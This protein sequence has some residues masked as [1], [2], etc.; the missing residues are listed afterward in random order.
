MLEWNIV[1]YLDCL[2]TE[3][4]LSTLP[5]SSIDLC[6]TD[7]PWNVNLKKGVGR[8]IEKNKFIYDDNKSEETYKIWCKD[9]FTELKRICNTVIIYCGKKKIEINF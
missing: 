5:D 6:I 1:I 9:W 7:P 4:G 8:T 3:K 2:N